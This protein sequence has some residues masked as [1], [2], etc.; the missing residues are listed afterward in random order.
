M[1][2]GRL[3]LR[4]LLYHWRGNAAV[5][6]GV[7]VGTAVLTGALLV[8]DSLQGSLRD[9]ALDQLGRIDHALVGGR[10]VRAQLAEE[11]APAE[12]APAILL[13]GAAGLPNAGGRAARSAGGVAIL[14]VDERFWAFGQAPDDLHD[15][16]RSTQEAVVLNQALA[17]TLHVQAGDPVVL[18]LPKVSAVPR[19]SLL[20]RKDVG[21]VMDEWRLTVRAVLPDAGLARF[22]LTPNPAP[23]RN[24]FVPLPALQER[25]GLRGRVNALLAAGDDAALQ[26]ALGRCLT[27]DDWGLEIHTP[28]SRTADL[29]A[30]LDRNRAGRLSR[31][32]YNRRVAQTFVRAADRDRDRVLTRA[33][34]AGFYN[35]HR[36]YISL[37]SRQLVL[38]PA[39][40]EAAQAAATETN[41]HLRAA[42][43]LVY[44]ANRI[45]DGQAFI[46]YSV[47]AALDPSQASPQSRPR[48]WYYP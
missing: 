1:T 18:R 20:G 22:T 30:K 36:R 40:A 15:F 34:V 38:E 16:W 24:A 2:S 19:E 9:R 6:L 21:D 35:E 4:S 42:P 29:F 32:E 3:L 23:P 11:L 39:A 13:R 10:F 43:T 5:L 17:G 14:G 7:A 12:V 47:V 27:L 48:P 33:E 28:A 26:E 46:P 8:G 31:S 44:L 45:S 37:E 25:L 41:P